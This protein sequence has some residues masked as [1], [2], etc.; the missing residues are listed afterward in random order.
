MASPPSRFRQHHTASA[1]RL[2]ARTEP[3]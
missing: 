1:L 2:H 3:S